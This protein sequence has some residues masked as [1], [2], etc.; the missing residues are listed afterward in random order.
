MGYFAWL[1]YRI[2]KLCRL[3]R[4]ISHRVPRDLFYRQGDI[5][6]EIPT[7][8]IIDMC[9]T[10]F[11]AIFLI[12]PLKH[13]PLLPVWAKRNS[14]PYIPHFNPATLDAILSDMPTGGRIPWIRFPPDVGPLSRGGAEFDS[15]LTLP[16]LSIIPCPRTY[17]FGIYPDSTYPIYRILSSSIWRGIQWVNPA[18]SFLCTLAFHLPYRIGGILILPMLSIVSYHI[19]D[20]LAE[21]LHRLASM[22]CMRWWDTYYNG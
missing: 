1:L 2:R 6:S 20:H 5:L 15:I 18:L 16:T 3:S 13:V 9:L 11:V 21:S 22:A 17:R 7:G 19:V 14:Y 12:S 8:R 4:N 10:Q